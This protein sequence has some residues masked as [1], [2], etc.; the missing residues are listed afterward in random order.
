MSKIVYVA[1]SADFLHHG[2]LNIIKK[3]SELGVV[4]IGLLTDE[5]IAAFPIL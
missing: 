5:A 1:M 2:H 3:A 4:T